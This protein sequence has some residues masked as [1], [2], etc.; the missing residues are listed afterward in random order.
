VDEGLLHSEPGRTMKY[1]NFGYLVLSRVLELIEQKS[2]SKI[3]QDLSQKALLSKTSSITKSEVL[4]IFVLIPFSKTSFSWNVENAVYDAA[5]AGGIKSSVND[6]IRWIDF[7]YSKHDQ[8]YDRGWVRA[9]KQS[10]E[11]YWHN[12]ATFG[13][14]TLVAILPQ[15]N[16]RVALSIDN[17]KFTKQWSEMAEQFE[18]YFY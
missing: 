2:F 1:S 6:L 11:A 14:Y 17:F 3:I 12:G 18:Q 4:P 13:S 15:Q 10:Y 7:S 5:G 16:I 8:D 9:K